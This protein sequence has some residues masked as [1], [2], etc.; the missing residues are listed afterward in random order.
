M[1]PTDAPA[2]TPTTAPIGA[3]TD[4]APP[5]PVIGPEAAADLQQV[6][7]FEL[8]GE[9]FT[10]MT[11]SPDG[12]LIAVGTQDAVLLVD[13]VS[14]QTTAAF[15]VGAMV[16]TLAFSPD[17]RALAA[18]LLGEPPAVR[19]LSVDS[20]APESYDVLN[21]VL[22]GARTAAFSPDGDLIAAAL[23]DGT[24]TIFRIADA[25]PL[26]TVDLADILIAEG[27]IAA[28]DPAPP[29]GSVAFSPDGSRLA[30]DSGGMGV[31]ALWDAEAGQHLRTYTAMGVIAGPVASAVFSPA[32]GTLIWISRGSAYLVDAASGETRQQLSHEDWI[33]GF[34]VA[35]D[36]SL[37]ATSSMETVDGEFQPVLKLWDAASGAQIR[38]LTGFSSPPLVRFSPDGTLL[39]SLD[40]GALTLWGVRP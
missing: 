24:A 32:W 16:S 3:P 14:G 25:Q 9:T 28:G 38:L 39:A 2:S 11:W 13:S 6:T 20:T 31:I 1:K 12:G 21:D 5:A 22:Q 36:E 18:A 33:Y 37:I 23:G 17:G 27:L 7:R 29:I 40:K 26:L 19:L 8:A 15:P 34:D 4:G 10:A 30:T 35:P